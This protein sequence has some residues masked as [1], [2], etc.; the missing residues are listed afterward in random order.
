MRFNCN[1]CH[2][3]IDYRWHGSEEIVCYCGSKYK[4]VVTVTIL[5]DNE[6]R[7]T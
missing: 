4:K 6:G 5:D 2:R 1:F 3:V 7:K